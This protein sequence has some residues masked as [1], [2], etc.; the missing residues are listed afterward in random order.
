LSFYQGKFMRLR[1]L[2]LIA[3]L[4]TGASATTIAQAP[5]PGAPPGGA[6]PQA[7][8]ANPPVIDS[9]A[10][11]GN[12]KIATA[13]IAKDAAIKAGVKINKDMVGGEIQRIVALYKK[14]G[15]DLSVSPDIAHPADGH[16]TVTFIINEDGKGGDGGAAPGGPGGSP[17]GGGP[18]GAGGPPPAGLPP[19]GT[20]PPGAR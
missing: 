1:K 13:V 10:Y 14:S 4:A 8:E 3:A 12:K 7:A 17:P 2:V 15:Y 18:P 19:A 9:I 20:A 6:P 11:Q 5:P 16:V